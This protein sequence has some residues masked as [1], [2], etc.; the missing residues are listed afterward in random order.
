MTF[1]ESRRRVKAACKIVHWC[2]GDRDLCRISYIFWGDREY[3]VF[4]D[5]PR[6]ATEVDRLKG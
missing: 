3:Y 5:S 1:G 2:G 6:G 4:S